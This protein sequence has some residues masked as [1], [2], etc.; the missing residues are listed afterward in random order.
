MF[1]IRPHVGKNRLYVTLAGAMSEAEALELVAEARAAIERLRGGF[2]TVTVVAGLEPLPEAAVAH[3]ERFVRL[4]VERGESQ[5]IRVVGKSA[6]AAV[7][8]EKAGRLA[9]QSAH[10]AFSLDEAER[11]LDGDLT[12]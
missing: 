9:G 4:C 1:Q 8:L 12:L 10:L 5:A 11:V 6:Q 7:Q 2:V 3:L